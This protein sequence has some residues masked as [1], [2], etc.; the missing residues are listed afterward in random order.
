MNATIIERRATLFVGN[1]IKI[2]G[3]NIPVFIEA[4]GK[5][6]LFPSVNKGI[7]IKVTP[8]GIEQE[9]I[10]SLDLKYLDET[11]KVSIGPDRIDIVSKK[12]NEDWDSFREFVM[13]ISTEIK[14][15]FNND[16]IRYALCASIRLKLDQ[17][18]AQKSYAKLFVSKEENLVEWQMRK[19]NRTLLKFPDREDSILVNNVYNL[20]RNSSTVNGE[21]L[22]NIVTLDLDIN[23]I[24]GS[25]IKMLNSL[26][27]L[28]WISAAN[29]IQTAINEYYSILSDE[30]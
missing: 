11:V 15:K 13:Q 17:D 6:K 22:T 5:L 18:H 14:S 7:G 21:N 9:D 28:F 29:T 4:F 19:V 27:E 12:V 16:I 26:Q 30:K 25:D 20:C 10:I 1:P 8:K 3:E 2:T 23:T 24:V